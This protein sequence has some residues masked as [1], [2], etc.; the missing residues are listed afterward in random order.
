VDW[1]ERIYKGEGNKNKKGEYKNVRIK[2][3]G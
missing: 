1:K 2:D 3:E